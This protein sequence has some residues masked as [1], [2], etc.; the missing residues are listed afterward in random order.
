MFLIDKDG[1]ISLKGKQGVQVYI[2]GRPTYMSGAD[3]ANYLRNLSSN[4]LDQIEIMTNPPAKYDAAGNAGIINIKTKKTK[5]LGYSGSISSTWSQG[6]YPK[7]SES[8]NFNYR[9]N[10]LNLFTT[11][12][13]N[14]R[15]NWQDLDIQRKF[16]EHSTKEIK[17]YFDQE[18]RIKDEGQSYNAKVGFDYFAN[19]KTTFGAVFTGYYN[20]GLFTNQSDVLISDANQVLLSQTL[21]KTSNDREWKNFSTNVNFRH[22]LDTSRAGDNR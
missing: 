17:S 8:F 22:L 1:N 4:Q 2:D 10:K 21:A 13:Y 6:R 15:K 20:P 14:Y 16:I 19:K 18:S 3:L 5:Q 9:K 11:L 7:V 12:G